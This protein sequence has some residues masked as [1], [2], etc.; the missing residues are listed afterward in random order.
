VES[1]LQDWLVLHERSPKEEK[2][3]AVAGC[4]DLPDLPVKPPRAGAKGEASPLVSNADVKIDFRQTPD[5][6]GVLRQFSDA[7]IGVAGA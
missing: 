1:S 4:L 5:F 2:T 7:E 3:A 6:R